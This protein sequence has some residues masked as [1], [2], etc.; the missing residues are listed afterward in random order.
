M[1]DLFT[2]YSSSLL[3]A[4]RFR[5]AYSDSDPAFQIAIPHGVPI[6]STDKSLFSSFG[7]RGSPAIEVSFRDFPRELNPADLLAAELD[8]KTHTI[9]DSRTTDNEGVVELDVLYAR[10]NGVLSR[11]RTYTVGSRVF[12][13]SVSATHDW[14]AHHSDDAFLILSSFKL[15]DEPNASPNRKVFCTSRSLVEFQLPDSWT[16]AKG[17]SNPTEL[18]SRHD[19][20]L[21][22]TITVNVDQTTPLGWLGMLH[23]YRQSL[24]NSGYDIRTVPI[25]PVPD[26]PDE[27]KVFLFEPEVYLR[28]VPLASHT[29]VFAYPK[30]TVLLS[31][32]GS[33]MRHAP[34]WWAINK[35][36]FDIVCSSL[37]VLK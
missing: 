35:R 21:I 20:T 25:F 18:Q 3:D 2:K 32:I 19:D 9:W 30:V 37:R 31:L 5:I 6:G 14:F 16:V 36:A 15:N 11:R 34:V 22:G 8:L 17:N 23:Q 7:E 29:L 26:G 33:H 12:E 13:V 10:E 4:R 28:G 1:S 27:A 24:V